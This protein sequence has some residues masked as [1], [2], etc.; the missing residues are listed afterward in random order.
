MDINTQKYF[1]NYEELFGTQGWSQLI[2][3][4]SDS[5]DGGSLRIRVLECK[6]ERDLGVLQGELQKVN[7]LRSLEAQLDAAYAELKENEIDDVEDT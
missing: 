3:D 6:T 5:L 1:D 2:N 7:A 4:L